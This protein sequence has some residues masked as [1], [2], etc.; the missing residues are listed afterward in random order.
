MSV[1]NYEETTGANPK[2]SVISDQGDFEENPK[3]STLRTSQLG[4]V[5][6]HYEREVYLEL[7]AG[8][9]SILTE[10]MLEESK[11]SCSLEELDGK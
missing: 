2:E 6:E 4:G 8:M 9:E 7:Q 10:E 1:P 3:R 5:K 11:H